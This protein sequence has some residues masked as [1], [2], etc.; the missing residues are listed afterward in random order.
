M[1]HDPCGI[2]IDKQGNIIV[3]DSW[4]H[5]IR[6]IDVNGNVTT[7]AGSREKGF[8]DGK[9]H[10]AEF[11]G[12]R[13]VAIDKEGNIIM[14]DTFNNLIRK[15]DAKGN[16][17]TIAG[18]GK[19]GFRDGKAEGAMFH[20]P[21]GIAIDK[22]GNIIVA[23]TNNARIRKIDKNGNVSTIAGTGKKGFRDG[24]AKSAMFDEPYGIGIDKEGNIIVADR[25]NHRIRK[26]DENGNVS[27]ITG[28]GKK[29]FLDGEA[30]EAEFWSPR[31]IGID[32]QG[33]I[34]VA[35]GNNRIRKIEI[36]K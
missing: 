20:F 27:T 33:N 7:I 28:N 12:P 36:K 6:K 9:A 32:K 5:R 10:K 22:E 17:S 35:D 1:F 26:I 4:N 24:K 21:Q 25:F 31:G 8:R 13:G 34:I 29:G 30:G 18:T 23:D 3:A 2:V 11:Y 14:A 15:I 19:K 16:M